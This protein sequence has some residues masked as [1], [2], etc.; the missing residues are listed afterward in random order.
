MKKIALTDGSVTLVDDEDFDFLSQW[1]WMRH[2]AGYAYAWEPALKKLVYMHRVILNPPPHLHVDHINRDRLD[3]RRSNLRPATR[4]E[5]MMNSEIRREGT[6]KYRGVSW[7]AE[8]GKWFASIRINKRSKNLGRYSS[9]SEAAEAY[10]RAALQHYGD[11]APF[12][13][14]REGVKAGQPPKEVIRCGTI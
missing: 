7:D 9:E 8:R 6:S 3:N 11:F 13:L 5:N 1:N 4:V 14:V 2:T 10:N 12:N